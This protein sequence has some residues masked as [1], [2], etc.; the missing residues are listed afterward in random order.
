MN[1]ELQLKLLKS[2]IGFIGIGLCEL[3]PLGL[4]PINGMLATLP[5]GADATEP[6]AS[7]NHA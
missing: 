1:H 6:L 5:R 7:P 4:K 2:T 3:G